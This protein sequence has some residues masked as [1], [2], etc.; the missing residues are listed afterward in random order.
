MWINRS[1]TR[2]LAFCAAMAVGSIGA[3]S[4][5]AAPSPAPANA[6]AAGWVPFDPPADPFS[7]S[8]AIDLRN[9][10]EKRAGDG[11]FVAAK[12]GQFVHSRTGQPV[13]FWAANG[14]PGSNADEL[15]HSAR[16]L[17]KHGVNL[18]RIHGGMFDADGNVAPEKVKHAQETV[19]ALKA[20]GIYA[21]FSIYFPI[22]FNPKADVP[23]LPGYDGHHHP[24]ASLMFN[25]DF[26]ERYRGWWKALLTTPDSH[27]HKLIDDPALFGAEIQNE[28]SYFFW[29]FTPQNIPDP[30]LRILETQFAQWL[31]KKYGSAD[32]A[33]K[34]WGGAKAARDN[35]AEGRIGFRPLWNM[36]NERT[37]RDKD[38]AA[39]LTE[40]QRAFYEQTYQYLRS[41]GFK[42]LI[43]A[44]NWATADPRV[45]GP[46]EKYTYTAGDFL[47]R[48]GYF[49]GP[50][51]GDNHEWSI[52]QSHEYADRDMLKFEGEQPGK[53]KSF[54]NS[55]MDPHYAGKPS[56]IS[57]IAV[58]RP[59]RFR[60]E[61][62]LYYACYAALQDSNCLVHFAFD[63]SNW[64]VKP[65]YFMQPWTMMAPSTVGQFPAAALIYRKGLVATG[66]V[67]VDLNLKLADLLDL[68]GTPM[69][70][71]A[72][73]DELRL[74][75]VPKGTTIQPGNVIDPLVHYAGRTR[76]NITDSGG[77]SKL[78]DTSKLIDRAGQ[79]VTSSTGQLRLDYGRGVL[80]INAASAQG[81]SGDLKAA[82]R[83]ELAD[84]SITSDMPLG[85]IVAVSLDGKPLGQ[86]QRILLQVMSEEQPT[87]WETMDAGN[88]IQRIKQ[89]GR[90]PW[91]IRQL[92]GTV[93]FKRADAAKLKV[94]ALDGNGEKQAD[95]G[96]AADL[97]LLPGTLYYLV[98]P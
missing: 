24:F 31:A 86:S 63:G 73:F 16:A 18:V 35:P 22:W 42:G 96:S 71:D 10:N 64:S 56:M 61:A 43:C 21:H 77:P 8:S 1:T 89:I 33:L 2:V 85:H 26:Q 68:Q 66:D 3:S 58:N 81:L 94:I 74:K 9:L 4:C 88:G 15:R 13:R 45:L 98:A 29:T 59:N 90:D 78:A 12:D 39:F 95:H 51:R 65:G 46:L 47:D 67:L 82:G 70:Q 55:I 7:S 32:A 40:S 60:S 79:S 76:V 48:H 38:T 44:S 57:E 37:P 23:G 30:E 28:D 14:C 54:V 50:V 87:G 75:D 25:K 97:V 93:K 20:E 41:L 6:A 69:P 34:K 27:G 52:R 11:G 72:A 92:S 91:T 83:T 80:T 49:S 5:S 62:P 53:P 19:E 36:A 17:A 84:L